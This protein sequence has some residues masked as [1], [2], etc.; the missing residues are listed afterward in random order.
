MIDVHDRRDRDA[1]ARWM[2]SAIVTSWS[3]ARAEPVASRLAVAMRDDSTSRH[4]SMI[5]AQLPSGPPCAKD[6]EFAGHRMTT[7]GWRAQAKRTR[8]ATAGGVMPRS[9]PA[10]ISSRKC[11]AEASQQVHRTRPV[12]TDRH[13]NYGIGCDRQ[14]SGRSIGFDAHLRQADVDSHE[15]CR[16]DV[17]RGTD[18]H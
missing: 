14:P 18:R 17:P 13:H 8:F 15:Y 7:I 2:R 1:P 10:Q 11:G 16:H 12:M 6:F 4:V 5:G 9:A 3:I